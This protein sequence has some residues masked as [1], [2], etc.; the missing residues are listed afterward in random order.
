MDLQP[1]SLGPTEERLS[2]SYVGGP[3]EIP[4]DNG[5]SY[6]IGTDTTLALQQSFRLATPRAHTFQDG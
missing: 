5:V 2:L 6:A 4:V 1:K 3:K